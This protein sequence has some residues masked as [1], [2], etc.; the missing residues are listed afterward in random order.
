M[1]LREITRDEGRFTVAEQG[2]PNR[3]LA[4]SLDGEDVLFI[5]VQVSSHEKIPGPF[6]LCHLT[7]D[8]FDAHVLRAIKYAINSLFRPFLK[9]IGVFHFAGVVPQRVTSWTKLMRMLGFDVWLV[10]DHKLQV[11]YEEV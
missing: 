10:D 1:T 11:I 6:A 5:Q 4:L 9:S 2:V 8:R 7:H 3:Y